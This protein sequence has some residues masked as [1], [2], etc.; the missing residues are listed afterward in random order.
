VTAYCDILRQVF[1]Q[2]HAR[3]NHRSDFGLTDN[4]LLESQQLTF[5]AHTRLVSST[6][7][8]PLLIGFLLLLGLSFACGS[9]ETTEVADSGSTDEEGLRLTTRPD[10]NYSIDDLTSVGFK[11]NRQFGSETVPGS[12]DIWYGF[13]NQRDIEIRFYE[14]HAA[15]L[16]FGVE[17][18]EVIIARTAGQRDPLIPVVNLYPAYAV[19]GNTVMLCERQLS[20]CEALI[21]AL[22]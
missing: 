15:A 14:S 2:L 4:R 7:Y 1:D 6:K 3:S 10:A 8:A 17:P 21:E 11:K 20:T 22:P 12:I 19:V 16:E 18:A 5:V 9:G 13:F